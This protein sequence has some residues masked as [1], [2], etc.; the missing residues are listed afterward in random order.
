[1]RLKQ[2]AQAGKIKRNH[3]SIEFGSYCDDVAVRIFSRFNVSYTT[4]NHLIV[5]FLCL[6]VFIVCFFYSFGFFFQFFPPQF[7][8]VVVDLIFLF[9]I[10]Y[11]FFYYLVL[12]FAFCEVFLLHFVSFCFYKSSN[13]ITICMYLFVC[14][15]CERNFSLKKFGMFVVHVRRF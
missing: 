15:E 5:K 1:M 13:R 2:K 9:A 4:Q 3:G 7:F 10:I 12:S 6:G 14:N 8:F 11:F